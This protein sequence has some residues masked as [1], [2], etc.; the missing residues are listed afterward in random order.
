MARTVNPAIEAER[1]LEALGDKTAALDEAIADAKGGVA[2]SSFAAYQ[3][4]AD[5]AADFDGF[6]ILI[7]YRIK[8]VEP[9]PERASLESRL[10]TS[11][12]HAMSRMLKASIELIGGLAGQRVLPLGA[13]DVFLREL[14][15]LYGLKNTLGRE[16]FLSQL[17]AESGHD[18]ELAEKILREIIDKAPALLDLAATNAA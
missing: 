10:L 15:S 3:T 18:V 16:P 13:K 17:P 12:V 1:F 6:C 7:E 5:A 4:F 8:K 2:R 9:G 14:R 11:R